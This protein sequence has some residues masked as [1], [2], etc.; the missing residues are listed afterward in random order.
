MARVANGHKRAIIDGKDQF[1]RP[2]GGVKNGMKAGRKVVQNC[3]ILDIPTILHILPVSA[4]IVSLVPDYPRV[5]VGHLQ[6]S[7]L[8]CSFRR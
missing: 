4:R 2:G 1:R 7:V 3:P 6:H 5:G 8:F